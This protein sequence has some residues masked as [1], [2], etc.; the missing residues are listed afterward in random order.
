[1]QVY[2]TDKWKNDLAVPKMGIVRRPYPAHGKQVVSSRLGQWLVENGYATYAPQEPETESSTTAPDTATS[3]QAE[4]EE[5]ASSSEQV[6][7]SEQAYQSSLQAEQEKQDVLDFLKEADADSIS[8]TKGIGKTTANTLLEKRD[9]LQGELDWDTVNE[10]LSDRQ[11][12]N[13]QESLTSQEP[14][15][16]EE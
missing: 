13:L 6:Y 9:R 15:Q 10:V 1:M 14:E 8:K 2:P 7:N 3:S 16:N 4:K 12:Y 5:V 11:L